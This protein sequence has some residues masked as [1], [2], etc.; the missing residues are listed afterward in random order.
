MSMGREGKPIGRYFDIRSHVV[1]MAQH[2]GI[3]RFLRYYFWTGFKVTDSLLRG[4]M[5]F[6]PAMI[7]PRLARWLGF[8][9]GTFWLIHR[10]PAKGVPI[11]I[12][13]LNI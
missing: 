10:R 7:T 9:G 11:L 4:L 13:I 5:Q 6:N 2:A 1:V 12:R 8:V 3:R